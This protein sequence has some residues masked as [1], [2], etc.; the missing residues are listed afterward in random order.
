[1]KRTPWN[2]EKA[3]VH[4]K[5]WRTKNPDSRHYEHV[6]KRYGLTREQYDALL[7][8]QNGLCAI[9]RRGPEGSGKQRLTVDHDHRTGEVRGLL[10]NHCNAALGNFRDDPLVLRAAITYL[11]CPHD[12]VGLAKL[13][14]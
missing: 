1:M 8:L 3:R 13:L 12:H 11:E 6:K 2:R 14:V 5:R 4:I 7:H 10:C 9:C